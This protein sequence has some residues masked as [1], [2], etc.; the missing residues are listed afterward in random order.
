M[1]SVTAPAEGEA[2]AWGWVAHLQAGGTTPWATWHEA[3]P[4]AGR[5]LP[6]AQQLELLRRLN[7]QGTPSADLVERVLAASAP[8]RGRPDL[9]LTGVLPESSFGSPPVDPAELPCLELVRVAT[10]LIAEDVVAAGDPA[11][12][13]RRRRFRREVRVVGD[14]VL[15]RSVRTALAA[16]GRP[17]GGSSPTV[18][19]L[20]TTVAEM[21]AD[22]WTTRAFGAGVRPWPD[23]IDTEVRRPHA[24]GRVDLAGLAEQWVPRVGRRK[25]HVVLDDPAVAMKLAGS[26]RRPPESTRLSAN[27]V[28]L[29]RHV[30]PVVGSLVPPERR[31]ALMWHRLHPHLAAFPGAPL[32]VPSRHHRRLGLL[33]TDLR[34]RLEHGDYAVHGVLTGSPD[35][36]GATEPDDEGVLA[37]AISVLLGPPIGSRVAPTTESAGEGT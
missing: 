19:I 28:E 13:R 27:A 30:A 34:R 33:T 16:D 22:L 37:L 36:R 10:S 8:G 24:S 23:W 2:R 31:T 32:V 20:G 18:L 3:A 29:A 4:Q 9:A 17:T 12:P 26:R 15:A 6:G 5:H 1:T 21:L 11:P 25:V 7:V 35:G 14:P